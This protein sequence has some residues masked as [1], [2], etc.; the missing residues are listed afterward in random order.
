MEKVEITFY[1]VQFFGIRITSTG[2]VLHIEGEGVFTYTRIRKGVSCYW[3][4]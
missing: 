1:S 2:S 4:K 3:N